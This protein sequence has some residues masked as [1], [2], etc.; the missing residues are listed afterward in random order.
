MEVVEI[1]RDLVVELPCF[2]G[3]V[4]ASEAVSRTALR[5]FSTPSRPQPAGVTSP[6]ALVLTATHSVRPAVGT[7]PVLWDS[8]LR[9]RFGVEEL[10]LRML[11]TVSS[12]ES[13]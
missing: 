10:Q 8:R 6:S 9:L 5:T 13:R 3:V 1:L 4:L 2:V 12:L 11:A 7:E